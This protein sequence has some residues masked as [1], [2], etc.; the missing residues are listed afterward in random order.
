MFFSRFSLLSWWIKAKPTCPVSV[1]RTLAPRQ[2][3]LEGVE[4]IPHDPG[5]DG[6]V[7]HTHQKW[8]H[9]GCNTCKRMKRLWWCS[10]FLTWLKVRNHASSWQIF[11]VTPSNNCLDVRMKVV[12]WHRYC[13]RDHTTMAKRDARSQ[14]HVFF[15]FYPPTPV[16]Q[17]LIDLHT[18]TLPFLRRWP[19]ANSRCSSGIPS[20]TSRIRN[21]IINAPISTTITS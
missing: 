5:H 1:E 19:M 9:Q 7:V 15:L 18:P 6:V 2:R 10:L 3:V 17:G 4:Q 11:Y 13:P 12:D 14:L 20:R 21:G 8:D 16:R